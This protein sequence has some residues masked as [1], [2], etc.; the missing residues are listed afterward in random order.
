MRAVLPTPNNVQH[1]QSY[2]LISIIAYFSSTTPAFKDV[3]SSYF[4]FNSFNLLRN[5][6]SG[7]WES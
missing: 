2:D 6:A 1:I 7:D 4:R 5:L 3:V